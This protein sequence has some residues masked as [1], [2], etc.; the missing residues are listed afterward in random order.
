M[1]KFT[2]SNG[3][4]VDGTTGRIIV[5]DRTVFPKYDLGKYTVEALREFFRAERDAELGRWRWPENPDYVVHPLGLDRDGLRYASALHEPSG[6]TGRWQEGQYRNVPP[7]EDDDL[8]ILAVAAYFEVHP[9]RKPWHDADTGEV[10][11][12]TTAGGARQDLALVNTDGEFVIATGETWP[13]DADFIV[14][15]RRIHPGGAS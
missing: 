7:T 13:V 2:A 1:D 3:L 6:I 9:E 5:R 10:W 11:A 8:G 4:T 14:S 12:V 15:A